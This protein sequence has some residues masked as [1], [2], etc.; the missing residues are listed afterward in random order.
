MVWTEEVVFCVVTAEVR[1]TDTDVDAGEVPD[2]DEVV[3]TAVTEAELLSDD[4]S[5]E[6]T[7]VTEVA[8]V[9]LSAVVVTA[10]V[11]VTVPEAAGEVGSSGSEEGCGGL[12][13]SAGSVMKALLKL[14]LF[15]KAE[16]MESLPRS[17]AP[18]NTTI[19]SEAAAAMLRRMIIPR[20]LFFSRY[21]SRRLKM[22]SE[23]SLYDLILKS[24]LFKN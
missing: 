23:I 4:G 20:F 10:A 18:I 8:A 16:R 13:S 22:L 6:E 19:I 5:V 7:A 3:V 24:L 21:S 1:E 12:V 15:R 9:P 17:P 14:P 2:A 11:V